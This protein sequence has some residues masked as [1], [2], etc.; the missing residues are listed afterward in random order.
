M[1][2]CPSATRWAGLLNNMANCLRSRFERARI[3]DH[4]LGESIELYQEAMKISLPGDVNYFVRLGNLAIALTLQ[5]C[6]DGDVSHLEEA[7]QL[8]HHAGNILSKDHL[9][10]PFIIYSLAES[11]G[12]CFRETGDIAKLNCA[13]DVDTEALASL[14]LLTSYYMDCTL[15]MVSHLCF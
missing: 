10:R 6:M 7:T 13:I 14:H 8:Y 5:F 3:N 15:Q 12:L 2:M 11:L 9:W 4:D 1:G